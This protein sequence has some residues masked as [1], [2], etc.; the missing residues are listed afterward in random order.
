MTKPPRAKKGPAPLPWYLLIHQLPSE[1]LY[2]RAKIRQRLARVGAMAL[3]NAAYVLPRRDEC[4]EDFQWIAEEAIAGG[5]EAY[6]CEAE[7]LESRTDTVLV[8]QFRGARNADYEALAKT[9]R[10]WSGSGRRGSP[11]PPEEDLPALIARVRKRFDEIERIDFFRASGRT[12]TRK[13]LRELENRRRPRRPAPGPDDLAG[14]TWVTRRGV[15]IDRIASAWL[16]RRFVDPKAR[17]RF[18]DPKEPARVGELSF[19][20]V[21]GDFSH[22]GDRCTFET[23]LARTGVAEHAL[24]EIAE[25]VHDIDLKD[26]KFGRAEAA[27]LEQLLIGL[28]LANPE[29]EA[30]LERG[31][32]LFDE[33][34]Q[35]FRKSRP[36]LS[37]EAP[38]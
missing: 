37:K 5:G 22:E 31:M 18:I 34:Y 32:L 3:K 23:L 15:H 12:K 17:F 36:T 2:L 26:G 28:V 19:D 9:I 25:I 29:D 27:G 7:F 35:S 4:L 20:V 1:P 21:G 16:I 13:L 10:E 30:R 6:V 24:T 14:R 33:L 11:V 8:E 38:K